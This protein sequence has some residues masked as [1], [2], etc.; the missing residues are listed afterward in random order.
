VA[1]P[2]LRLEPRSPAAD[3]IESLEK[4]FDRPAFVGVAES[5]RGQRAAPQMIMML[6][7][8]VPAGFQRP[9]AVEIA[10]LSENKRKQMIPA[11]ERLVIGVA[12]MALDDRL[13]KSPV[14]GFD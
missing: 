8:G 10:E 9:K 11:V 14:E 5:R 1:V 6:G 7:I 4:D 13:E 12:I 2:L 3:E